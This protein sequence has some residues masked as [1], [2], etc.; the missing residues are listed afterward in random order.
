MQLNKINK[1]KLIISELF[2]TVT[3]KEMKLIHVRLI[4]GNK[5]FKAFNI[6]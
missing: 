1:Q 6:V 5:S 4:I 3:I 2:L